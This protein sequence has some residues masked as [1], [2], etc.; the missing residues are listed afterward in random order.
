ME[1]KYIILFENRKNRETKIKKVREL[2]F[3]E[4]CTTAYRESRLLGD[5]WEIVKIEKKKE[6]R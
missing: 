4:A 6:G 3:P 2:T 5:S 1:K